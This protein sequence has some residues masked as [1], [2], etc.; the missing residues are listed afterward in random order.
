MDE[1]LY[2]SLKIFGQLKLNQPLSKHTTFKV[3]G[4]AKYFI[5]VRS[6]ENLV[7]LLNFLSAEGILY[8]ILGSGSNLLIS[9]K[10]FD[11][12][13]IKN[14]TSKFDLINNELTAESGVIFGQLTALA[15]REGLAG[16]EWAAGLPG[17]V[18]GAVRGNAG[19]SGGEIK[20]VLS[21]IEIWKDGEVS[22]IKPT[23]CAF[24]Y[25]ESIFKHGGGIVLGA[26]FSLKRGIKEEILKKMQ[27]IIAKRIAY[28]PPY[29]SAGSF[30]KNIAIDKL[31]KNFIEY[32]DKMLSAGR[33]PVGWLNEKAGLKGKRIGG[34]MISQQHGNF[35]INYD[36]AKAEDIIKLVE[37]VKGE[38]YNRF[39]IE[40]EE[41]VQII[42]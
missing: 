22:I 41:E 17:T 3:G 1:H 27:E 7:K 15:A 31:P 13:V 37:E 30:F 20:D 21:E 25:R 9:D 35:I 19:A 11:G 29:P 39:N 33:L 23:D 32:N 28:Y 34:A 40:L 12:V 5:E 16:L 14:H 36:Q 10:G 18:G 26:K 6:R 42:N 24:G 8:L 38:V 2:K 4:P